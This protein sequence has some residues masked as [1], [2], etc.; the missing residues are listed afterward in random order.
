[1][2]RLT[3]RTFLNGFAALGLALANTLHG[4]AA[5]ATSIPLTPASPKPLVAVLNAYR[6][7]M[8]AMVKEFGLLEGGFAEQRVKGFRYYIG[9]V[10]G[11]DVVVFE[12]GMSLVNAAMALQLA[13]ER[14]PISHVLFAGVAG[15]TDP[16]LR[17]GD[18]VIPEKWAYHCEA[19]YFNPTPDGKGWTKA[20]YFKQRYPNFGMI[21]PDEMEAIRADKEKFERVPFFP[22]DAGLIEVAKRAVEKLG[23]VISAKT[24]R[25]I[26]VSIGGAGVTGT[27]FLDN[28]DYRKFVHDTWGARC[29]D[30][31]TT[32]Y[33][34]VCY[35]NEIPFLA[36]RALSDLAGGQEPGQENVIDANEGVSSVHAV[37]VLRA[38]LR[39]M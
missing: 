4:V 36:V 32:A 29:A 17:V 9:Q 34:H 26:T 38:I 28:R 8:D 33:A 7:E 30:M 21:F 31:E 1:M 16:A 10:E 35:T 24:G 6:P 27:V 3:R 12:T 37:K 25:E 18:V 13:F 15:G 20:E 14:L 5:V 39:E 22:V 11:K 2:N 19:A 23:P